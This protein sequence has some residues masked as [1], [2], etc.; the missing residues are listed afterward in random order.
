MKKT[1]LSMAAM[2]IFCLAATSESM[3]QLTGCR[4][5]TNAPADTSKWPCSGSNAFSQGNTTVN[6]QRRLTANPVYNG[7]L[8]MRDKYTP[9]KLYAYG[10]GG[11]NA[12][13]MDAWNQFM[14]QQTPWHGGYNYWRWNAPTALVVPPTAA[15]QT[16]YAWG[17][18]QTQSMPINHQF[19]TMNP[20]GGAGSNAFASPPYLPSHTGQLGVYPVRA[21]WS[22]Q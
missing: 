11:R 10:S 16:S 9:H 14:G 13:R 22:H 6:C 20:G 2:A 15:F 19:G 7:Y 12:A 18:G 5:Q 21:P 17:V 4:A 1:I 8:A 3:A